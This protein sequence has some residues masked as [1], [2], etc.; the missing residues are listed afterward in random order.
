MIPVT[1]DVELKPTRLVFGWGAWK[2]LPELS[3]SFGRR[4]LVV[5]TPTQSGQ[6]ERIHRL[7]RLYGRAGGEVHTLATVRSNPD[8]EDLRACGGLV[9]FDVVVGVG[10][11]SVLDAAKVVAL[12][13]AQYPA[14][15][16]PSV[17][18]LD[19]DGPS[20]PLLLAP[21]TAGS[22]SELSAGAIMSDRSRRWKG[23]VRG[24]SLTATIAVV[25]PS[26]TLTMPQQVTAA[27]GFDILTHAIE[28]YVS[29]RAN[30]SSRAMSAQAMG[31]VV[32]SL[33]RVIGRPGGASN[34]Q[35]LAFASAMMGLNLRQVGTALPHRMQYAVAAQF[36]ETVHAECLAWL[37]PTWM[38]QVAK[39][40][41]PEVRDIMSIVSGRASADPEWVRGWWEQWL[42]SIGLE[43]RPP[44]GLKLEQDEA[45]ERLEGAL[46]ND[47]LP[48]PRLAAARI[49]R[50]VFI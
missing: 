32:R 46:D 1:L 25:D 27:T 36:P 31:T 34:R 37:Y 2:R 42:D 38:A 30:S 15:W 21:T 35:A 44:R 26:L 23:G 24:R 39:E 14:G 50:R 18:P 5:T 6:A 16:N 20:L 29:R 4:V 22:G 12:G 11:G 7:G 43:P 45:V 9:G 33:P 41:P 19:G 40:A 3:L 8:F 13:L 28:S 17:Q 10:G 47:P 49:F 48:E